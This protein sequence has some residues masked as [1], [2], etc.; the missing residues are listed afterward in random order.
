[1]KLDIEV[2]IALAAVVTWLTKLG[3]H[4]SSPFNAAWLPNG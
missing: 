2:M 3:C 4:A 1:V